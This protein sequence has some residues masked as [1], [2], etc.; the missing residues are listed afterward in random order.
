MF[1]ALALLLPFL[2]AQIPEIGSKLCPMHLPVI[3]CGFICGPFWGMAVG[4]T[5]P[6]LRSFVFGMPVLMPDAIAMAAELAV[7]A[8]IA[9]MLYKKLKKTIVYIY[10]DLLAAMVCGRLVWGAAT[11][12]LIFAGLTD[13]EIGFSLIWTRTVLQ[14]IPAIILQLIAIPLIVNVLKKNKLMLN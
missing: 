3:L 6:L 13:G 7:Y 1:L 5:A 2:T 12:I 11:F 14:S 8:F 10:V 9:G 4:I